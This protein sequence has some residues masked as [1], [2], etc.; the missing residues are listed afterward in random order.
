MWVALQGDSSFIPFGMLLRQDDIGSPNA[1]VPRP[2]ALRCA[3]TARPYGPAPI[4]ATSHS[5]GRNATFTT[6]PRAVDLSWV[7]VRPRRDRETP[8]RIRITA[9]GQCS[10]ACARRMRECRLAARSVVNGD[11]LRRRAGEPPPVAALPRSHAL[12]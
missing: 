2:A 9:L 7:L 11:C 5:S 12:L 10:V 4:T 1:R 6:R 8:S 3:A